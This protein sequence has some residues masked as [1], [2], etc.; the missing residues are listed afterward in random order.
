MRRRMAWRRRGGQPPLVTPAKAGVWWRPAVTSCPGIPAFAGMTR[1][2]G[3][4]QSRRG[5]LE[6]RLGK[7]L[8]GVER[9]HA[10]GA[11]GG[12]RLAVDLV[13]HVA[14]GEDAGHARPRRPL[15]DLDIAVR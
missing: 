13:H 8:L 2:S 12:D 15:R 1:Y 6:I 14:A 3:V 9:G 4:L 11:G 7:E 10:A 5:V